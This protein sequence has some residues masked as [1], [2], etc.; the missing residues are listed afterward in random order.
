M[1][2][3]KTPPKTAIFIDGSNIYIGGRELFNIR[4]RPENLISILSKNKNITQVYYFSSEDINNRGQTRFHDSLRNK[5]IIVITEPIVER[6]QKIICSNCKLEANPICEN[7]GENVT[8]PPHKSKKVDILL[9]AKM[10]DLCDTYDEA[11]I[12]T[13]DQ[14]FIPI[15]KVLRENKG[16]KIYA[17]SFE[18]P[19]SY[20]YRYNTNG[21]TILDKYLEQ[22]K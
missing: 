2:K 6:Q 8:L 19:L 15:I 22:L 11:I 5:G 17:A 3:S 16:K 18:K 4:V 13:G 20:E 1:Q 21:I 10:L 14:D 9:G 7:C 12:A